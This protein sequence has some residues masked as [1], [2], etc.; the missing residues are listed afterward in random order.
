MLSMTQST[1]S[2]EKKEI[3]GAAQGEDLGLG[4]WGGPLCHGWSCGCPLR[5]LPPGWH[6]LSKEPSPFFGGGVQAGTP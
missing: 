4:S 2:K 3:W 1:D 5:L 6:K